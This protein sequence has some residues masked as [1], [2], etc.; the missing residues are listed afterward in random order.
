MNAITALLMGVA[1]IILFAWVGSHIQSGMDKRRDAECWLL[2]L[3][4]IITLLLAWTVVAVIYSKKQTPAIFFT[5]LPSLWGALG[6]SLLQIFSPKRV[7][8]RNHLT[9]ALFGFILVLFIALGFLADPPTVPIILFGGVLMAL[10]WRAWRWASRWTVA[11]Y[12]ILV[13]LLLLALW[14]TDRARPL[15]EGPAWLAS[16][17]QIVLF[18]VPGA[19]VI[20]A[21]R[22]VQAGFGSETRLDWRRLALALVSVIFILLILGYQVMLASIWDVA[23]DGLSGIFLVGLNS[24]AGIA[25][26]L[27]LVWRL[28][29]QRKTAAILFAVIVPMSMI[30]AERLGILD[31]EGKWGTLPGQVTQSRSE[32]IDQAIQRFQAENDAY[33]QT[34]SELT[35]GYLLYIPVPYIIPGQDWCYESGEGYYRFGYVYREMFSLPASVRIHAARGEPPDPAWECDQEA[36]KYQGVPGF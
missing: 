2:Y 8:P 21:A 5:L 25:S 3:L 16:F 7:W 36:A 11:A 1:P 12:I 26:A 33:P 15:F 35:P 10:V 17:V 30:G 24:L 32:K 9:W 14:S 18:L 4:G 22:L 34:L 20:V 27:L 29:G 13:L 23:T 28:T 31:R 19:A 6:A